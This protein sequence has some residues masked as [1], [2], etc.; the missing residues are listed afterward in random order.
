MRFANNEN[1]TRNI[2]FSHPRLNTLMTLLFCNSNGP[3]STGKL[4]FCDKGMDEENHL[5]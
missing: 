3:N 1:K 2:A 5:F 4:A